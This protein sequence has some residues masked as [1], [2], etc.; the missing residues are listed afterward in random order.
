M[1]FDKGTFESVVLF[2][3][4]THVFCFDLLLLYRVQFETAL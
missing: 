1:L 2:M 3:C 4:Q